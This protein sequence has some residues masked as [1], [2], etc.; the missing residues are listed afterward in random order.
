MFYFLNCEEMKK[1]YYLV[2]LA[3]YVVGAIGG[4][5]YTLYIG[6]YVTAAGIA[7][8]AFMAL[9]TAVSY[10]ESLND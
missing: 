7:V 3:L 6:E 4:I 1:Y 5:G 8:L 9:P 2:M 10:W